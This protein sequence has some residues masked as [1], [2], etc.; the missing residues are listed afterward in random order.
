[1]PTLKKISPVA[2]LA[3]SPLP[4]PAPVAQTVAG[5][6]APTAQ[7]APV[8]APLPAG[9]GDAGGSA[10]DAPKPLESA[11]VAEIAPQLAPA[12]ETKSK[13]G[14]KPL[15]RDAAGNVI[16]APRVLN[17]EPLA[18]PAASG[19]L[20]G[21]DYRA[22][23]GAL[24]HTVTGACEQMIGPEWKPEP[25]E[26]RNLV[27]CTA[28]YLKANN[29]SDIPP[30]WMLLFAVAGYALPRVAHPNTAAKIDRIR[31]RFSHA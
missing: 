11:T 16:R 29:W 15:P 1:M 21:V 28:A 25:A 23:A 13:R 19:E 17:P 31:E 4:S 5:D 2:A 30:G 27:E 10:K 26:D 7:I 24:V 18:S 14:R 9:Q 20:A 3:A 8:V 12:P 22:I 6:V